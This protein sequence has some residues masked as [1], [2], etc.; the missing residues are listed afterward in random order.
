MGKIVVPPERKDTQGNVG[1]A[2]V[3]N[4]PD[5]QRTC[6][7][8]RQPASS[9]CPCH[10]AVCYIVSGSKAEVDRLREVEALA[11]LVGGRRTRHGA[12]PSRQFLKRLEQAVRSLP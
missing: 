10:H 3:L 1:C 12:R 6:G 5:G 2:F 11:S 9:Y 4:E 7:A 8:A